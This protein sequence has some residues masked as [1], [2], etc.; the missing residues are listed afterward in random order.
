M[1]PA[2]F[3]AV[4]DDPVAGPRR[5]PPRRT[6]RL[7]RCRPVG[8]G[9]LGSSGRRRPGRDRE[10]LAGRLTPLGDLPALLAEVRS[11]EDTA[12]N[13]IAPAVLSLVLV[14]LALLM[15]LLTAASELRLPELALASLR[16]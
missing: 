8:R 10:R 5:P 14:A 3:D 9:A 12:R 1:D 6:S 11:Q 16:G 7:D 2:A 15:R 4:P 13:S